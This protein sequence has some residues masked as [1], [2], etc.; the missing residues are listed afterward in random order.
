MKS[1]G[2]L[3]SKRMVAGVALAAVLLVLLAAPLSVL[4]CGGSDPGQAAQQFLNLMNDRKFGEAYDLLASGSPARSISREDFVSMSEANFPPDLRL[5]NIRIAEQKVE[6]DKATVKWTAITKQANTP[7]E[8]TE[9]EL[10]L[11]K[12]NDQW[13]I[14]E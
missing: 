4:G 2:R 10:S 14:W 3:K 13:W 9:Q 6:G 11:V 8:N 7:D 5:G 12:E 1:L